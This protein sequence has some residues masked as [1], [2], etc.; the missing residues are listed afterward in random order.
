[1]SIAVHLIINQ[2]LIELLFCHIL[3]RDIQINPRIEVSNPYHVVVLFQF[4]L[5]LLQSQ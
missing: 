4:D 3:L 2:A 1:M 5:L